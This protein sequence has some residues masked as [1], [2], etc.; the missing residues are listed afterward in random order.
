LLHL[1][2]DTNSN[3]AELFLQVNNNNTTDNL[4]AIHFGNNV[5]ETL[6]TILGGTSG[7]N[8][9][10]YLTFSTSNAGTLSEA[11]RI[12]ASGK[13]LIG[14]THNSLYNSSTQADA[15][16]LI[17]GVNDNI[18]VARWAGT[19]LFVNRMSTDGDHVDFR[20]DGLPVGSIG[21]ASSDNMY[22]TSSATNHVGL[23]LGGGGV[24]PMNSG[25]LDGGDNVDIGSPNYQ[26]AD[27][28]LAGTAY[29]PT[30]D[31]DS[32][33]I[34]GLTELGTGAS[35]IVESTIQNLTVTGLLT[36]PLISPNA[37]SFNDYVSG[38]NLNVIT[39]G[40]DSDMVMYHDGS[41]SYIKDKGTGDLRL[42]TNAFGVRNSADTQNMITAAEGAAVTLYH[43]NTVRLATTSSGVTVTGLLTADTKSFTI[44]H[45]TKEGMKLRY[46]SLEGPEHGVY[47]RGRLN[48]ENTI[49]LPEV[50]LGLVD[51]DTITV[52]L[53]PIGKGECWVE[54]IQDNTVKVGGHLNCFYMVL[55]ERKDVDKLEVEFPA[56][57]S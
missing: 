26:F 56:D 57:G 22:I 4:G 28:H 12:D 31:I 37:I 18:Q 54:D 45:P 49:E 16:A 23:Y 11:A 47:V 50:W 24:L 36:A 41:H 3:G 13:L 33:S 51:A 14:T 35:P 19:P 42:T 8:N 25:S 39:F 15:G 38:T 55:A 9:S 5:D 40:N 10:S 2:G 20:K 17:D 32:G 34:V 27:L 29:L 7:A 52:N 43:N 6:N 30:V 44:D 21:V 46:G 53:T 1:K 48:G